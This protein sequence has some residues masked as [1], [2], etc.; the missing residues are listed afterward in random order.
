M[1]ACIKERSRWLSCRVA[2]QS[3]VTE[4]SKMRDPRLLGLAKRY[5]W[6]LSP[7]EALEYPQRVIARVMDM[8]TFEDIHQLLSVAGE[9]SLR[10]V[11]RNAEAG[12]FRPRSWS[13]WQYLLNGLADGA[14]PPM[15]VRKVS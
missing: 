8:G 5:V 3:P 2:E 9:D 11:L 12:Q 10:E 4:Y 1:T 7:E 6:W 14:L 13:Y 15:P